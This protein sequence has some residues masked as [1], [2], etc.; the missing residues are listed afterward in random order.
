MFSNDV[1]FMARILTYFKVVSKMIGTDIL[2]SQISKTFYLLKDPEVR[3]AKCQKFESR[4]ANIYNIGIHPIAQNY[5]NHNQ[6]F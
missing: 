3:R 1:L 2:Q 4:T 6:T 5:S